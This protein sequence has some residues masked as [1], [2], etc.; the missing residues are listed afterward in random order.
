MQMLQSKKEKCK[1]NKY[2]KK[3]NTQ[4]SCVTKRDSI[5]EPTLQCERIGV[6]IEGDFYI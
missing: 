4:T 5:L 3:R 2:K 6:L 1:R